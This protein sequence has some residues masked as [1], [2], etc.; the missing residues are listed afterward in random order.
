MTD[1]LLDDVDGTFLTLTA[2]VVK[3]AASDFMLDSV[4]RRRGGAEFRR[5]LVHDETDGLTLNFAGDYPGGVTITGP[6]LTSGS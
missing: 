2:R 6:L 1:L 4:D 3:H 5:A